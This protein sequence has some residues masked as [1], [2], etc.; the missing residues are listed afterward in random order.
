MIHALIENGRAVS[1][2]T[3]PSSKPYENRNDWRTMARAEQVASELNEK[4]GN[5]FMAV[6]YGPCV[7]PRYDVIMKPKV[8]DEVSKYFNGDSTPEGT[9]TK[10]SSTMKRIE[11]STG[12]VFYRKRKS[13]C[14]VANGTWSM[15][16]GHHHSRN[17]SF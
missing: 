3:Q 4:F 17:P 7:W 13:G 2:T 15:T 6:D 11:T 1:F 12:M 5:C 9:I 10:V 14:W 8:G 16:Q